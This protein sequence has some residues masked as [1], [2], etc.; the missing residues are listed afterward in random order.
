MDKKE[1]LG[2]EVLMH[3]A[4]IVQILY[5]A[6]TLFKVVQSFRYTFLSIVFMLYEPPS[7]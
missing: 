7:E 5:T 3:D 4:D 1:I 2:L 6:T